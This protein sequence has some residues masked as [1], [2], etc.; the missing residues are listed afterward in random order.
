MNT[1]TSLV[2]IYLVALL[3]FGLRGER[4][5]GSG[6]AFITSGG[7]AG[8]VLCALSLVSTII[9]GSATLGMGALAQ[10]TGAAAFWWLGVG[11]IGLFIHGLFIAPKIR[12]MQAATL[13]EV[14]GLVAGKMAERWAGIII[15]VSWIA[16][17]AAQFVALRALLGSMMNPLAAEVLYILIAMAVILHT[18]WGGQ[19]AV[20]RTDA[21]QALLLVG[22]FSAVAF[23]LMFE[24]PLEL[25]SLDWVP[26][27]EHFG[28]Y[29]WAKLMLLVGVTYV[30]G[31][32]MFS[33]TFS[34]RDGRVARAA[35]LLAVPALVWFGIVITAMALVNIDSPQPIADWLTDAS[36]MPMWLKGAIGLGLVSALCGSADTVLL[37]AAGIV[38]RSLLAHDR[39]SAVRWMIAI[40]GAL[41]ALSVYVSK[42]IIGLLLTAYSFFVPG[43]AIP[44][45]FVLIG[46][47]KVCN[48]QFWLSG[49]VIGGLCGLA[50]NL[51][52]DASCTMAGMA[53]A[54]LFALVARF[55]AP[56]DNVLTNKADRLFG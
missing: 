46:P 51:T 42:D 6:L 52:G 22:G 35:A 1:L 11:A 37:S 14:V 3:W 50:G 9:G 38:E 43:V 7:R 16:V 26:Y 44:L 15:A 13:P 31:P 55:R 49:A 45:L 20:L 36:S 39:T 27:G 56:D 18:V 8:V 54:A 47:V 34:A 40:F 25:G 29:D 28:L 2:L 21:F 24:H 5:T 33:R 41:A 19:S 48:T 23:W 4:F 12:A 10:K 17:T 30:I 53:I 32:D